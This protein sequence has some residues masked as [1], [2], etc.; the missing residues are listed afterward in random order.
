[1]QFVI[2]SRIP[3]ILIFPWNSPPQK[4]KSKIFLILL[5][6]ELNFCRAQHAVFGKLILGSAAKNN[7]GFYN[8]FA[9]R[10]I[11]SSNL[12]VIL[13]IGQDFPKKPPKPLSFCF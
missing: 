13:M 1:L 6:V 2:R 8:P 9:R 10:F 12:N 5:K 4:D 3:A 7:W 11:F